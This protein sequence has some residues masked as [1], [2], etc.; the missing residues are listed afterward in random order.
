MIAGRRLATS[1]AQLRTILHLVDHEDNGMMAVLRVLPGATRAH[2]ARASP[3]AKQ[4]PAAQ[5]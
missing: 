2:L 4:M 1:S 3:H 5:Q